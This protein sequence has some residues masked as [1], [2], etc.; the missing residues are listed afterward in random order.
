MEFPKPTNFETIIEQINEHAKIQNKI[1]EGLIYS[2]E[3]S[4]I[5][6][7]LKYLGYKQEQIGLEDSINGKVFIIAFF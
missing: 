5:F 6:R 4:N 7:G 2:Y 3:S 1:Y